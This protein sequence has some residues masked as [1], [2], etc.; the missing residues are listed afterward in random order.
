MPKPFTI[1]FPHVLSERYWSDRAK[2]LVWI[3]KWSRVLQWKAPFAKWFVGGR[4]NVSQNCL[5]R[6]VDSPRRNKA[7]IVWEGEPGDRRVLT[8]QMA[9]REVNRFANV[10]KSLGVKRGDRVT[11]YLPA[12]PAVDA[13]CEPAP[14]EAT[15]PVFVLCPSGATGRPKGVLHSA[16]GYLVGA[17]TTHRLIFDVKDR[18]L[19]WCTADIGWVAGHTYIVYG[20]LANGATSFLYEGAP[21][22]PHPDRFWSI[23]E[24]YG[25]TILYTAPTAIR[26]FMRWGDEWPK[27]HDLSTLRLLGTV[28]EPINPEAWRWYH[29]RIAGGPCPP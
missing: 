19:Y 29:K 14:V 5:D 21:D 4:I 2:E 18:D 6:H 8:Y 20:P 7:A 23:V 25:V 17:A 1:L 26:A 9:W 13:V 12:I 11:I 22:W 28:G 3:K 10:L 15:D 24:S 27:K 16:G